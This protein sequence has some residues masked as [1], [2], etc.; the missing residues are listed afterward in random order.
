[1]RRSPLRRAAGCS[2]RDVI[3]LY[4]RVSIARVYHFCL[5]LLT[6]DSSVLHSENFE[7]QQL[8]T[9]FILQMSNLGNNTRLTH[10]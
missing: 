3:G 4:V 8:P 2:Q 6:R 1:M 5:R 9:K 7:M 10:F